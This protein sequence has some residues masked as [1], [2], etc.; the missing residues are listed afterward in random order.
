MRTALLL[1]SAALALRA[2][3]PKAETEARKAMDAFMAAFNAK[4]PVS[5]AAT[6]NYPHVRFASG[7][8]KTWTS[9]EEF[10]REN[11]DYAKRLAPWDHSSWE[12]MTPVQSG[13]DKVHFTVVFVRYDSSGK[14]IGRFPS[15]YIVTLANGYWGIQAR[16]SWAP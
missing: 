15:L 1:V 8:V 11:K 16:S 12:S 4:D 5:W 6:L 10:A 14:V 7:T 2:Q 9:A 13:K 3:D